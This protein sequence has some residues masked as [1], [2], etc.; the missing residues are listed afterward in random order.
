MR[1]HK[2]LLEKI[3]AKMPA[4]IN[5][6]IGDELETKKKKLDFKPAF[7]VDCTYVD[8]SILAKLDLFHFYSER[9]K[10][11]VRVFC[12]SWDVV[13]KVI[14]IFEQYNAFEREAI[15]GK[16]YGAVKIYKWISSMNDSVVEKV[17]EGRSYKENLNPK[18]ETPKAHAKR[19]AVRA[20][21]AGELERDPEAIEDYLLATGIWDTVSE[22]RLRLDIKFVMDRTEG[23]DQEI[24]GDYLTDFRWSE[25]S[26]EEYKGG[27]VLTEE[28][29]LRMHIQYLV[30]NGLEVETKPGRY[31][32]KIY[33]HYDGRAQYECLV[34]WVMWDLGM[35]DS[36]QNGGR[37]GKDRERA[38]EI[39][40]SG[41][42]PFMI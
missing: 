31:S 29:A 22:A 23:W 37:A 30:D 14:S 24:S 12:Q 10:G 1:S 17:N 6:E 3:M 34:K 25:S 9:M 7:V 27:R 18:G 36:I 11:G 26:A 2:Q 15:N 35:S 33:I 8:K 4:I 5:E 16:E 40:A 28:G 19:D 39:I 21:K 32:T 13:L 20:I 42:A 38:E 41:R